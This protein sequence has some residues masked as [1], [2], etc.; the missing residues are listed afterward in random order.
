[1]SPP[2]KVHKQDFE[3]FNSPHTQLLSWLPF[4]FFFASPLLDFLKV[5]WISLLEL[6]YLLP[7]EKSLTSDSNGLPNLH[8]Q[9]FQSLPTGQLAGLYSQC[10][11]RSAGTSEHVL[12][13]GTEQL[14]HQ[15]PG[16]PRCCN[17]PLSRAFDGAASISAPA[18]Q[19]GPAR[20]R[21]CPKQ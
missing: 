1:M 10:S 13:R 2:T 8:S 3:H 14:S 5:A 12:S 18:L 19:R 7:R 9:P 16:G 15:P 20:C 6:F 17:H 21:D 11:S 4:L